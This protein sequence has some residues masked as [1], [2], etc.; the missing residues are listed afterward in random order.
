M[1]PT[2]KRC[3]GLVFAVHIASVCGSAYALSNGDTLEFTPEDPPGS[4]N[5]SYFAFEVSPGFYI[6]TPTASFEGVIIG[7]EQPAF[8]SH[9]GSPD[10]TE[11]PSIDVPWSFFGNTGMLHTPAGSGGTSVVGDDGNG[12][13]TLDF[14]AIGMTWNGIANVPLG[15]DP[16]NPD[17]TGLATLICSTPACTTGNSYVL[18]FS[19]HVPQGDPSGFGGVA[20]KIH[21]EGTVNVSPD[22]LDLRIDISGGKT[23]EC[24]AENGNVVEIT[25][26]PTVPTGDEVA[27]VR[28]NIDNQFYGEGL[29]ITPFLA[30]GS[31]NIAASLETKNGL[32]TTKTTSA[33]IRDTTKPDVIAEFI[34]KSTGLPVT[35]VTD[36]G[37]VELNIGATDICDPS[38]VITYSDLKKND[39]VSVSD[40]DIFYARPL[41]KTNILKFEE[42]LSL[43]VTASD[44]SGNLLNKT[45]VLNINIDT[46]QQ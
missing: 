10:G 28:W 21:L 16:A 17:D 42:S 20:V 27:S 12:V 5:G 30:L 19:S 37:L 32:S 45:T 24:N 39:S 11:E 14:S 29:V 4:G 6:N 41:G 22:I 7:Q 36:P 9:T 44:A 1:K 40:G 43:S 34:L 38:P 26:T 35:E 18:D 31:H 8:G 46:T 13:F 25:A 33:E 23:Q 15:G 2:L 3:L